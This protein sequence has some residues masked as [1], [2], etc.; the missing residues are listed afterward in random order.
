VAPFPLGVTLRKPLDG[1]LNPLYGS[2]MTRTHNEEP[3]DLLLD[4]IA[5]HED[6]HTLTVLATKSDRQATREAAAARLAELGD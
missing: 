2:Y 6:I 3:S 1:S 5:H 4:L